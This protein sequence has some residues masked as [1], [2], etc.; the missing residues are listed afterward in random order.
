M[1]NE[2][3]SRMEQACFENG[4]RDNCKNYKR[5]L[6]LYVDATLADHMKDGVIQILERTDW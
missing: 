3:E 6:F 1:D 5:Q 4:T 2:E